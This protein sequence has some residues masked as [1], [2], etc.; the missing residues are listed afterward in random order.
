MVVKYFVTF[1][2]N[3]SDISNN[4][5][6]FLKSDAERVKVSFVTLINSKG[7]YDF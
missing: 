7:N 2:I 5:H 1:K 4:I 3:T 6:R